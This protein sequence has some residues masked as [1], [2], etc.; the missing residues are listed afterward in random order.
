M[1]S[2]SADGTGVGRIVA[3][4]ACTGKS[5]GVDTWWANEALGE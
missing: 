3:T 4:R 1:V 2:S 5:A